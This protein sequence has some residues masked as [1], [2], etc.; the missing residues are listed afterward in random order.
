MKTAIHRTPFWTLG[1]TV[2]DD[3]RRIVALAEERSLHLDHDECQ[4]ARADLTNPRTRLS[5]EMQWMPGVSPTKAREAAEALLTNA[6]SANEDVGRYAGLPALAKANLLASAFE[7]LDGDEPPEFVAEFILQLA[8][9]ADEIDPEEVRRDLN[10]DRSVSGFPPIQSVDVVEA[11]LAERRGCYRE[12]VREALNRMP[13]GQLVDAMNR[14]ARSATDDG[15]SHPPTLFAELVDSYENEVHEFLVKEA[16]AIS[17]LMAKAREVAPQGEAVVSRVFDR[18]EAAARN[19]DRV[20]QP[21]QMSMMARGIVHEPS[22]DLAGEMRSLGIELFNKY[23]MASVA[24]RMTELLQHLFAELPEVAEKLE[25]DAGVLAELAAGQARSRTEQARWEQ[26]IAFEERIGLVFKDTLKISAAGVEWA[27]RR[28]P[29]EAITRVRWGGVR[30]SVNGIPTG[31]EF[32]IAF[33]DNQSEAVFKT[34]RQLLYST[35]IEKLWKAACVRLMVD[36]LVGLR[37]G[38]RYWLGTAIVD[39]RG[40]ELLER[41][42][43]KADK[44]VHCPWDR[45]ALGSENGALSLTLR[46]ARNTSA[47]ASYIDHSNTHIWEHILRLRHRSNAPRLSDVLGND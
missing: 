23:Q 34:S 30:R 25:E 28:Y 11:E 32:T 12:A 20:A 39:D 9:V 10:E 44:R 46:D 42:F 38:E 40:V 26:E 41:H 29:L 43:L 35:F 4:K 5:A 19:W 47:F 27:G 21:I 24:K 18:I 15:A 36:L 45:L 14:A 37:K 31:T 8:W 6:E 7:R 3:R 13:P 22:H 17:T 2:R 33:G 1:A 16:T